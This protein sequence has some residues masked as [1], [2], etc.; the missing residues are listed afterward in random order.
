VEDMTLGGGVQV[1]ENV[2][3]A[4]HVFCISDT[5]EGGLEL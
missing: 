2:L 5:E 4:R 1:P 3:F